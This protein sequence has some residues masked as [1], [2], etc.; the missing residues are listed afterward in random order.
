MRCRGIID[1]PLTARLRYKEPMPT[2]PL[3]PCLCVTLLLALTGC[4]APDADAPFTLYLER[5]QRTLEQEANLNTLPAALPRLPR[6]GQ[7]RLPTAADSLG[8]LDFLDLR[9]CE[10]QVTIGKQNS[11]LGK[12][13]RDSQRLLLALEFLRLAPAC[14]ELLETE[15]EQELAQ[16]LTRAQDLKR[17][18]LPALIFNA[19]LGSAEYAALWRPAQLPA[20]YPADT[21]SEVIHALE[22][23]N[24]ASRRW[25]QGDY[26]ADNL[27][28]ELQLS[29]VRLGDAGVLWRALAHQAHWLERADNLLQR[30][31]MRG[32]LC[33]PRIRPAA[34]DILP[35]VVRK[36]FVEGIQPR[37]AVLGRRYHQLLPPVVSLEQQL[38]AVLPADYRQWQEQRDAD[39]A[40]LSQA[41]R[42]HVGQLQSLLQSCSSTS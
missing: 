7:L 2:K 16:D 14:I 19:T 38:D 12:L 24:A 28:F 40:A 22:Q 42:R 6:E 11:S 29:E 34:A 41:P 26:Q 39:M 1:D 15:G 36:F 13:A 35:N 21:S 31:A 23:I 33:S 32:P 20:G 18:Q 9:G 30:R 5:L 17:D 4:G 3:L 8:T 10:L 25:L 27:A 37:A